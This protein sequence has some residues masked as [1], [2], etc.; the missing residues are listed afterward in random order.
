MTSSYKGLPTDCRVRVFWRSGFGQPLL[1]VG[2][3]EFGD[4]IYYEVVN[5]QKERLV[6]AAKG[7]VNPLDPRRQQYPKYTGVAIGFDGNVLLV[8]GD[9]SRIYL[10]PASAVGQTPLS[11]IE[12]LAGAKP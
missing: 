9:N 4:E 7:P 8:L 2:F 11:D 1:F 10:L 6:L 3:D 12:K 5:G